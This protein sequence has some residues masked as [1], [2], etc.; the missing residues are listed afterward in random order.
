MSKEFL[1]EHAKKIAKKYH[2]DFPD[3]EEREIQD[4]ATALTVIIQSTIDVEQELNEDEMFVYFGQ[5][6]FPDEMVTNDLD[7]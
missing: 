2:M 4:V 7:I 1:I 6:S 5:S 3:C